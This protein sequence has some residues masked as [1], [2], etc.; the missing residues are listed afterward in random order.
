MLFS[1]CSTAAGTVS[2][3]PEVPT[4]NISATQATVSWDPPQDANGVIIT[5]TVNFVLRSSTPSQNVRKRQVSDIVE[6]CI[7]GGVDRNLTVPG[8]TTSA[9]LDGLSKF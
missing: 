8:D 3:P 2:L 9:V 4:G 6:E 7:N 1:F 5:Y